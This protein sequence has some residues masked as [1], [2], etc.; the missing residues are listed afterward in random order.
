[1]QNWVCANCAAGRELALEAFRL[2]IRRRI[3]RHIGD[4]DEEIRFAGDLAARGQFAAV[5]D[6]D[7]GRDQRA[8]VE[9]EH[10]LRLRLIARARVVAAQHQ[11]VADA[12]RR[13][14]EQVALQRDPVAVAAGELQHRLDAALV[15]DHGRR[16]RTE[17]SARAGAIGDVHGV[18]EIFKRQRLGEQIVAAWTRPAALLR[19]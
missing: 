2:P 1:M 14:A 10:R 8:G 17:M 18:G 15:Q 6:A 13:R 16:H 7:R 5:A 19:R 11:Q 3:D 4:A 12:E 9:I